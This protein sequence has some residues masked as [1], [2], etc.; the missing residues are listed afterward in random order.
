MKKLFAKLAL[1]PEMKVKL[2]FLMHGTSNISK[3]EEAHSHP[4][5][6]KPP[7]QS[8]SLILSPTTHY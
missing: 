8:T 5:N 3:N 4:V 1:G 2:A 7:Y 6:A